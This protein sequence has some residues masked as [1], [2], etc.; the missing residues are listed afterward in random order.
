MRDAPEVGRPRAPDRR[1]RLVQGADGGWRE[2]VDEVVVLGEHGDV[3]LPLRGSIDRID[4]PRIRC[5]IRVTA[6]PHGGIFLVVTTTIRGTILYIT[7]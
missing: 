6:A 3:P 4:S 1:L 5:R 2:H 7:Q